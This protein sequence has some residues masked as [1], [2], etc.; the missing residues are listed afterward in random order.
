MLEKYKEPCAL[1]DYAHTEVKSALVENMSKDIDF[2]YLSSYL[3]CPQCGFEFVNEELSEVNYESR[4]AAKYEAE[5]IISKEAFV[6]NNLVGEFVMWKQE[7]ALH[8]PSLER[9]A[10]TERGFV[11]RR[12]KLLALHRSSLVGGG[13]SQTFESSYAQSSVRVNK[14]LLSPPRSQFYN[15]RQQWI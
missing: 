9:K 11:V 7:L 8:R 3:F 4:S 6:T 12:E 13:D 1:C 14:E 5:K 15:L 2:K 10:R